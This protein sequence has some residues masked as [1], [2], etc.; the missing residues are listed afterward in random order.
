MKTKMKTIRPVKRHSCRFL[1]TALTALA[2]ATSAALPAAVP[3]ASNV[4]MVQAANRLVT[5]TYQLANAPAVVTLDVETNANTSAAAD[6]PGWTSIGGEALW[7]ATGDVWKKVSGKDTYT[8]TWQPDLS[9]KDA[10][11]DGLKIAANGARAVVTAWALDNT[12]D[13][14]VVDI[15]GVPA[16]D[17]IRYYPGV[18]FLP[19]TG[20]NQAGAAVTNNPAYKTTKLLMRKI[21]ASGVEWT[22]GSAANET[23]RNTAREA[24]HLVTLT[25]NY[26]I[27]VFEVTQ[28]QWALIAT[29]STYKTGY[30]SVDGAMRPMERPCYNEIRN[31]ASS[32]AVNTAF[33]WPTAP[34]PSSFLGLLR[35]KTG[36]DF[37]LP[38]EA[39]WEFAARSGNGSG[40]WNDGSEVKNADTDANLDNLGRYLNNNP[41]GDL[42]SDTLTPATGG[43]AIVGSY[44]P[45]DWGLYDMHGNVREWCLDWQTDDITGYNGRVNI[46]PEDSTKPL[47]GT[48]EYRILRGGSWKDPA[49][50][51]RSAIRLRDSP[52]T[53]NKHYGIRVVCP[54]R[55]P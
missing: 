14:M 19:K 20:Y 25:N 17:T 34:N 53:R 33:N 8:I 46:D 35:S 38:S 32:T 36:L 23:Q 24:T 47:S 40:Y 26:Y 9:W 31:T 48:S 22:M 29:N 13:Y 41:S 21:L 12:P 42:E 18:D 11:G 50:S 49:G 54:V 5:I 15:T 2:A 55:L 43:T 37:D 52:G 6:D 10:N 3:E 28:T 16:A 27:G 39:Q 4:T 51:C 45:S 44:A 30:F 1:R 7:N